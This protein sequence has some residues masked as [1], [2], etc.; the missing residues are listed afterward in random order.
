MEW[1]G[2]EEEREVECNRIVDGIQQAK[3]IVG[4]ICRWNKLSECFPPFSRN[5]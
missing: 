4:L 2:K 5:I 3:C 1:G